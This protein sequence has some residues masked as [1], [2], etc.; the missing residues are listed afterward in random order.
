MRRRINRQEVIRMLVTVQP[1]HCVG[2]LRLERK[3]HEDQEEHR[4]ATN[5]EQTTQRRESV[6][7][8][9]GP[10]QVEVRGHP[11]YN[12]Y[13]LGS[14]CKGGL[15]PIVFWP[16]APCSGNASGCKCCTALYV[17]L[18][19]NL[20]LGTAPLPP[21]RV[22]GSTSSILVERNPSGMTF[23]LGQKGQ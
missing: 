11:I 12:Q 16:R 20:L 21:P 22:I 23:N 2:N 3:D 15:H 14:Q 5:I 17:H 8:R 9:T 10:S 1:V 4:K 7:R 18:I 6:I 13:L 19:V